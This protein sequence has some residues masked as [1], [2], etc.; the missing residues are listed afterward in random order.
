MTGF[1]FA[2]T[3]IL[4]V[5]MLL[6]LWRGLIYEVMALL[7]WPIAFVVSRLVV[8]D[9]LVLIPAMDAPSSPTSIQDLSITAATYALAF[10][11]VLIAWAMLSRSLSRLMRA[12]GAGWSDRMMGGLFGILRGGLVLLILVWMVGL[13]H[14]VEHPFW[15]DAAARKTLENTA[16]LT[17][18]W[19]PDVIAQRISYEIRS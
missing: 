16:L 12:A 13:T 3:G 18:T 17:K 9:L 8:D 7:G 15:R 14:F 5:S 10:I 19:L 4:L 6:G 1:D 2:V 11:A